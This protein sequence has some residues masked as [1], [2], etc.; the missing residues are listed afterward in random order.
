MI[1]KDQFNTQLGSFVKAKREQLNMS[2]SDLANEMDLNYQ[3]ISRLERGEV[4]PSLYW[5]Y[6]LSFAFQ[7]EPT[8]LLLEFEKHISRKSKP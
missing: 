7:V 1:D 4:T 3:N 6:R 8:A 2:Q 5:F